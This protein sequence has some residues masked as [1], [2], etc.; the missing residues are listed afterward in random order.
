MKLSHHQLVWALYQSTKPKLLKLTA[1]TRPLCK[2]IHI[3]A[4]PSLPRHLEGADLHG[5]QR[6]GAWK[7]SGVHLALILLLLRKRKGGD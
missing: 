4:R 5:A 1:R 3:I 2:T 7:A 6:D